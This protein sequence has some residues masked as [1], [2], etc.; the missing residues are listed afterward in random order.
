MCHCDYVERVVASFS[1]QIQSEYCGGNRY[2]SIE[3]ISLE[4]FSP[5][6]PFLS[7]SR[8][9]SYRLHVVLHYFLSDDIKQDAATISAHRKCII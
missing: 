6:E 8:S 7:L 9:K 3:G 4:S 5:A 1:H 2:V